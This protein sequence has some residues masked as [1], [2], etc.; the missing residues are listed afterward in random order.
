MLRSRKA[1][2]DL[3]ALLVERVRKLAAGLA[4]VLAA[5]EAKA[6]AVRQAKVER[7]LDNN[8]QIETR[9]QPP[10]PTPVGDY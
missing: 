2:A 6:D 1:L 5:N 9:G 8:A 3:R 10:Q 4:T 7:A